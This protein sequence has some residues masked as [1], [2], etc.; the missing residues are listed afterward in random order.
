MSTVDKFL[1]EVRAFCRQAGISEST[2]SRRF[3]N[4]G[5]FFERIAGGSDLG[6]RTMDRARAYMAAQRQALRR[7]PKRKAA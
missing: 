2:F 5:K 4:D 6:V 7:Q 1:A 3:A